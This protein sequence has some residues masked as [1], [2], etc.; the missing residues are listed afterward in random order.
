MNMDQQNNNNMNRMMPG[1]YNH[2]HMM[3][4]LP[5][6]PKTEPNVTKG[7]ILKSNES[8][9]DDSDSLFNTVNSSGEGTAK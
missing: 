8:D 5:F 2:G 1:M 3:M 7:G 4:P 9:S 6:Q